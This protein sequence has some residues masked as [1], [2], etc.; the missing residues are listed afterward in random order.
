MLALVVCQ[1]FCTHTLA[2]NE[3]ISALSVCAKQYGVFVY[4]CF[5]EAW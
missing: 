5:R 2:I 3:H 1:L 4:L